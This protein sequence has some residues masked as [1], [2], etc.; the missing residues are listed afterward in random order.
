[1]DTPIEATAVVGGEKQTSSLVGDLR[2][3]WIPG[4][5]D[6]VVDD[7]TGWAY[8]SS[9]VRALGMVSTPPPQGAIF[10]LD[11]KREDPQPVN[12]T[13][14]LFTAEFLRD[15]GDEDK[16]SM[17]R[18]KAQQQPSAQDTKPLTR[19]L[20]AFHPAG[21]HLYVGEDGNKR[22]FVVN[23]RTSS[24]ATVEIFEVAEDRLSHVRTVAD[25]RFL[26]D[27][28]EVVAVGPNA[29]YVSNER[30]FSTAVLQA[31]EFALHLPL[32]SVVYYDGTRFKK[33][34]DQ[35]SYPNGIAID[36]KA[37]KL[38]LSSVLA[39]KLLVA[40]WNTTEPTELHFRQEILLP[41]APDNLE[42][43]AQGNLWVGAQ[44]MSA[45]VA[46]MLGRRST[47]PSAVFRVSDP[48]GPQ[49]SVREIWRDDGTRLSTSSVAR[50]YQRSDG[51]RILLIGACFEDRMLMGELLP[52]R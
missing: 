19:P 7:K 33:A 8:V 51:R 50:V 34:A 49:P 26:T 32:G 28:N 22:L 9:Q 24:H 11:L 45:V 10:G 40:D 38:Y 12:L 2:P 4:A 6:I 5:E 43:D 31:V 20:G 42:W 21:I 16:S 46:L 17:G 27:P 48:G 30:G 15:V 23:L 52:E 18:P 41:G 37:G 47:A 25:D 35:L 29:F 36:R 13:A 14:P 3:I 39:K 44:D 1:M